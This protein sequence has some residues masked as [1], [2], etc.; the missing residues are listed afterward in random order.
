MIW[1]IASVDNI[2]G[3][4]DLYGGSSVSKLVPYIINQGESHLILVYQPPFGEKFYLSVG[5]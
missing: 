5:E 2:I 4:T 3:Q 1:G